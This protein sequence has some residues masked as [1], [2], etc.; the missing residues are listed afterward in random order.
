MESVLLTQAIN[1]YKHKDPNSKKIEMSHLNNKE[2]IPSSLIHKTKR[3]IVIAYLIGIVMSIIHSYIIY[4]N[5][6]NVRHIV[7][8]V[9]VINII[10]LLINMYF[11]YQDTLNYH[12][13]ELTLYQYVEE[14]GRILLTASLAIAL[15]FR[16]VINEVSNIHISPYNILFPIIV[17]FVYA[18]SILIIIWMPTKHGYY[19][20]VLRDLKTTLLINS[21]FTLILSMFNILFIFT[22]TESVKVLL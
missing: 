16:F 8:Y 18:I 20:R 3:G 10:V 14:N 4:K 12:E 21:I 1:N 7:S 22:N 2:M 9:L 19:L 6:P 15:L 13:Q 5:V 17:S 11:S